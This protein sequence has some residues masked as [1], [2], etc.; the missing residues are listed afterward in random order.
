MGLSEAQAS[1]FYAMTNS[2]P[3]AEAFWFDGAAM[4]DWV[5]LDL[6]AGLQ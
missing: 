5:R 1:A 3:H 2:V 4:A 6:L